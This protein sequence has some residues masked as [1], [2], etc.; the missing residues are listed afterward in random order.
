MSRTTIAVTTLLALGA[1]SSVRSAAAFQ[2]ERRGFE[3]L[4]FG[5]T[6][7]QVQKV[8]PKMRKLDKEHLGAT[9]VMSPLMPRY[10]QPEAT[11]R[12]LAEPI[13][14]E[15]RFW[16]DQL[17]VVIGYYGGNSHEAV[18]KWLE[19]RYGKP[20]HTQ[21]DPTWIGKQISIVTTPGEAWF[22][23]NDSKLAAEAQAMMQEELRKMLQRQPAPAG[24]PPGPTPVPP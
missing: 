17:F 4:T 15:L 9:A 1:V 12:G 5:Q 14:L 6:I 10:Y 7:A 11:V 18:V 8:Y 2:N 13:A 16:K 20:T 23:L 19:R 3:K 22:S 21:P 24:P